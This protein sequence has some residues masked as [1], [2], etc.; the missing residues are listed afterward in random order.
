MDRPLFH[1]FLC[2]A[3]LLKT[4]IVYCVVLSFLLIF[5][6]PRETFKRKLYS[7]NR[8]NNSIIYLGRHTNW[9]DNNFVSS[10]KTKNDNNKNSNWISQSRDRPWFDI[11]LLVLLLPLFLFFNSFLVPL[12]QVFMTSTTKHISFMHKTHIQSNIHAVTPVYCWYTLPL[13]QFLKIKLFK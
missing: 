6:D 1:L 10:P 3:T 13:S 2:F 9:N 8:S 7:K 5:F 11:F 4:K 12:V